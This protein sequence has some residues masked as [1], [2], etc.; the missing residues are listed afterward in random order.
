MVL[1]KKLEEK[2]RGEGI[3]NYNPINLD[4]IQ[5][6]QNKNDVLLPSDLS[7]YFKKLNGTSE[8]YTD[9]LYEFYSIERIKKVSEEFEKWHG[10][11]NYQSLLNLSEIE[12]LFVFAN[13]SFNLFAY[14]IKLYHEKMEI[15]E[16]FV[17]CGD[18]YKK[19]AN[20]FSEFIELYLN[21]SIELQLNEAA[22]DQ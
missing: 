13:Y 2:W 9:E 6:F 18:N 8:E 17:L 20:S 19:I 14:A 3:K 1:L 4:Y 12:N 22:I 7:E 5:T 16:V 21:D 15:N 10:I 11:P